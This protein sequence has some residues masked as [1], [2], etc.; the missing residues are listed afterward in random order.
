MPENDLGKVG[1]SVVNSAILS[2]LAHFL[3]LNQSC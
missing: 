3:E 1:I 2:E